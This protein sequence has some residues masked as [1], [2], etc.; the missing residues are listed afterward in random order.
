M[1]TIVCCLVVG[2]TVT[3]RIRLGVWLVSGYALYAFVPLSV[4]TVTL[5]SLPQ[6]QALNE[7]YLSN[8]AVLYWPNARLK[9]KAHHKHRATNRKL[10]LQLP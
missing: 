7:N 9:F 10:Q 1:F 8:S 5:P 2:L 4:F 6:F 3:V